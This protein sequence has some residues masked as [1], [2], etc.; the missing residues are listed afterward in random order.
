M[1][2]W[3]GRPCRVTVGLAGLRR[4][5]VRNVEIEFTD[6]GTR[7]VC[8]N[9]CLRRIKPEPTKGLFDE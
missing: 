3:H 9:R 4:G 2:Q 8:P 1:P 7:C 6:D 5:M